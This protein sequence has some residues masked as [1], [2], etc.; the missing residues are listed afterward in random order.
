MIHL[1]V[2]D[3]SSRTDAGPVSTGTVRGSPLVERE[4]NGA[5]KWPYLE[6]SRL[7]RI[8]SRSHLAQ[9]GTNWL[10]W[11]Y[12]SH[13]ANWHILGQLVLLVGLGSIGPT[14]PTGSNRA[15]R[16]W[17]KCCRFRNLALLENLIPGPG[18]AQSGHD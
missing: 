5:D 12:R 9:L 7:K 3:G 8:C 11:N 6:P 1:H 17:F 15:D 13:W 4:R 14:G 10:N 2:W 16:R 18:P